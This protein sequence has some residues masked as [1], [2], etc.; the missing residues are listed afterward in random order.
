MDITVTTKIQA[1][2]MTTIEDTTV[3]SVEARDM[4]TVTI[5]ASTVDAEVEISPASLAEQDLLYLKA[6]LYDDTN[7]LLYRVGLISNPQITLDAPHL[8]MGNQDACLP[9]S[10]DKLFVSNPHTA[11]VVLT[12]L[13]GRDATP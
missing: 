3:L 9:A 4:I 10:V 5:P 1:P 7:P 11:D 2:G 6:S 12:V 13:V 8:F